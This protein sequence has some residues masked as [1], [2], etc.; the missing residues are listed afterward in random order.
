M[1][2]QIQITRTLKQN[3]SALIFEKNNSF[4]AFVDMAETKAFWK[5]TTVQ[6]I[7]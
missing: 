6:G 7:V 1:H 3:Q 4:E 5:K 2:V